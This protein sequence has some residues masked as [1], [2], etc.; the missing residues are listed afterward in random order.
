MNIWWHH[1]LRT[2]VGATAILLNFLP[3]FHLASP[4]RNEYLHLCH[5]LFLSV[6]ATTIHRRDVDSVAA[7]SREYLEARSVRRHEEDLSHFDSPVSL[8]RDWSRRDATNVLLKVA[9]ASIVVAHS[10]YGTLLWV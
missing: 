2:F 3:A 6:S 8:A 7:N 5:C 9:V 1:V 4:F 10:M